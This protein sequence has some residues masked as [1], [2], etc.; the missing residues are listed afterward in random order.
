MG[1]VVVGYERVLIFF[2][3]VV[4]YFKG[5]QQALWKQTI[6]L[7]TGSLSVAVDI[8][9][10]TKFLALKVRLVWF[11]EYRNN[12]FQDCKM[13]SLP[14]RVNPFLIINSSVESRPVSWTKKEI[15]GR[16]MQ[17][18]R[19]SCLSVYRPFWRN[20]LR[21]LKFHH[22]HNDICDR[23][24]IKDRSKIIT[25]E[26]CPRSPRKFGRLVKLRNA[27]TVSLSHHVILKRNAS[28]HFHF[29]RLVLKAA[30]LK[31]EELRDYVIS[32]NQTPICHSWYK[33]AKLS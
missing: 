25:T 33:R 23:Q 26:K 7:K 24:Y 10:V 20:K 21:I 28:F 12:N 22:W 3:A 32:G 14:F 16:E 27:S 8:V 5:I 29:D 4:A 30:K 17:I 13:C 31:Q 1:L 15:L 11:G 19:I 9:S 18:S 2:H 6:A